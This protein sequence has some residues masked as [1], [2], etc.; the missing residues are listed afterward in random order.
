[1]K[2][3]Q[4]KQL[5]ADVTI[6][7]RTQSVPH[8]VRALTGRR[9]VDVVVETVGEATWEDSL[10]C[11][12]KGGRLVTCGATT[13]P[14]VVTDVRRLFWNQYS[15]LGSTL[16]N[17]AEFADVVRVLGSGALRPLVDRVYPMRE[18]RAAFERLASGEQLGKIVVEMWD[19]V[20]ETTAT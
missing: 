17:A 9:G 1:M 8:E 16:G 12:A 19:G 4:A 13:G 14:S 6:N 15:I 18:V 20:G 7:H 11:L 3:A 2:L 10:R 5:G